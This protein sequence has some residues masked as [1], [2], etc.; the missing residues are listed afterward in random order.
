MYQHLLNQP[1][2]PDTFYHIYNRGNNHEDLFYKNE[3][4]QYFLK[5]YHEYISDY[6]DTY[7]YCLLSNHFHFLI[8]VKSESDLPKQDLPNL[9]DLTDPKTTGLSVDRIISNQF[10]LL[11]LSYAKAINKQENR[12]GS[13]FQKPFRRKPVTSDR[14]LTSLIYYI[15]NN[16]VHHGFCESLSGYPWSSFATLCGNNETW[17]K[18]D[19]VLDFFGGRKSLKEY[20]ERNQAED[21]IRDVL[22]ED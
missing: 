9:K 6:A 17:I 16:P 10:R 5:K 13:L 1:L 22:I 21:R 4:Y 19:N 2:Y 20:H 15:H 14:Y 18:R 8:K 12:D 11:F 7:A 3:N